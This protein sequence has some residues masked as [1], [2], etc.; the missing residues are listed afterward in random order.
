[1][2][3]PPSGVISRTDMP[4]A[5]GPLR[6]IFRPVETQCNEIRLAVTCRQPHSWI[7]RLEPQGTLVDLRCADPLTKTVATKAVFRLISLRMSDTRYPEI[8]S[9]D[10]Q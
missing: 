1:M 9:V 4:Q 5:V 2:S 10:A 7:D 6:A 8:R 3:S